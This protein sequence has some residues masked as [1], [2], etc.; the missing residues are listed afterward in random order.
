MRKEE[1]SIGGGAWGLSLFQSDWDYDHLQDLSWEAGLLELEEEDA[2]KQ[3][4]KAAYSELVRKEMRKEA[5]EGEMRE[6]EHAH[7]D[8]SK[9]KDDEIYYNIYAGLCSTP[10]RVRQWLEKTAG[11]PGN[12]SI[13]PHMVTRHMALAVA[14]R[15][16]PRVAAYGR[17][18]Y[19]CVLLGAALMT[20]GCKLPDNF[21]QYLRANYEHYD[22]VGLMR[23][24][25]KQMRKALGPDGYKNDGTA[26]DFG[27]R[28]LVLTLRTGWA[29]I[30]DRCVPWKPNVPSPAG[31]GAFAVVQE[32]LR[33]SSDDAYSVRWNKNK[34]NSAGAPGPSRHGA[35][36]CGGCGAKDKEN[37]KVLVKCSKCKGRLYCGR[38]CQKSEWAKHKLV[39][40]AISI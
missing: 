8:L 31:D 23:D 10:K 17:P 25:R 36:V 7:A 21:L 12:A 22:S 38:D 29:P 9:K 24:A 32:R 33:T 40:R 27:S 6:N 13:L 20:M 34:K 18:G 3:G 28:G 15:D 2:E 16:K 11:R 35:D 39:C 5:T 19:D 14:A 30:E 26:Y 4:K 37:G 1:E